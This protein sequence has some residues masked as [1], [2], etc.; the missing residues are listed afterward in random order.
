MTLEEAIKLQTELISLLPEVG[1][2]KYI[3]STWI[4]IA[5]L[6]LVQQERQTSIYRR[7][8]RL[9]GETKE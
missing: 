2:N 8:N 3:A 7:F 5:A 1:F 9:P 6:K 4:G